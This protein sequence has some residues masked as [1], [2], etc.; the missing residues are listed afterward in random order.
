MHDVGKCRVAIII[1]TQDRKLSE[2]EYGILKY[3]PSLG[4]KLLEDDPDFAPY[5]DVIRG[6]H[7]T[8]DGKGYPKDFD[9]VNSPARVLIDLIR[10]ADSADAGTD[11]LGRYYTHGKTFQMILDEFK[12]DAGTIYNPDLVALIENDKELCE[13]ISH[14]TSDGR[15]ELYQKICIEVMNMHKNA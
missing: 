3:H 9:N 11:V 7:K 15:M 4:A 10:L 5:V 12:A 6:H 8:Y 13:K 2:D 1:N 14:Q